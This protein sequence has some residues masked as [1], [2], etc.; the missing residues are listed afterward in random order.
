MLSFNSDAWQQQADLQLDSHPWIGH[1][2]NGLMVTPDSAW[3]PEMPLFSLPVS[4]AQTKR[5]ISL[6]VISIRDNLEFDTEAQ[7]IIPAHKRRSG[8]KYPVEIHAT[9]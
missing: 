3:Y 8:Q 2:P 4:L 5:N 6:A 1:W 9:G 7:Q